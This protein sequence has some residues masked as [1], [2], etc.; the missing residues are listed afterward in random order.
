MKKLKD[1]AK[2]L[3]YKKIMKNFKNQ[4]HFQLKKPINSYYFFYNY[5][6]LLIYFVLK[7]SKEEISNLKNKINN[8]E[9]ICK[10]NE[11]INNEL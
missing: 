3:N 7:P 9:S 5:K 4:I 10:K 2:F 6:N 1:L 11:R 8:L